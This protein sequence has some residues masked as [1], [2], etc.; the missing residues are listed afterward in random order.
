MAA[1]SSTKWDTGT[2]GYTGV[3]SE[4]LST[5]RSNT[6]FT[7]GLLYFDLEVC[8]SQTLLTPYLSGNVPDDA[9]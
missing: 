7:E 3:A 2:S 9:G 4:S 1:W 6:N 8:T 5:S